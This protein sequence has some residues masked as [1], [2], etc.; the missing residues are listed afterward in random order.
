MDQQTDSRGT[1]HVAW[2][3]IGVVAVVALILL[4]YFRDSGPGLF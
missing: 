4:A 3:V 1:G 2:G